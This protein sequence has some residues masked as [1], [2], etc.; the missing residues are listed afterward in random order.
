[1]MKARK[2]FCAILAGCVFVNYQAAADIKVPEGFEALAKGQE[3][4]ISVSLYDENLGLYRA[5]VSLENIVFLQPE[6]LKKEIEKKYGSSADLDTMLSL[7]L[8]NPLKRN[9]GL[10][11]QNNH[12]SLGCGY[13]DP[14]KIAII[15]DES[16][17]LAQIFLSDVFIPKKE[18]QDY[19][20]TNAQESHNGFIHQQNLNIVGDKIS[21]SLSL[22]GNGTLGLAENAYANVEWT[23]N[24]QRYR[25][26]RNSDMTVNNAYVRQDLWKKIYLQVGGMDSRDIFSNSGGSI[27]LSQL[28]LNKIYGVR[29]GS[30]QAW[31]NRD[32]VDRG[33]PLT[34]FLSNDSRVDAYRGN[35]LLGS[36]FLNTGMHKIDTR[37]F[38]SGSYTVSL[39]IYTN[40]QLVRTQ[41]VPYTSLGLSEENNFRWFMQAG[42]LANDGSTEEG[43]K[44]QVIAGGARLPITKSLA[45]TAGTSLLNGVNYTEGALDWT[46][47]F[48]SGPIDGVMTARASY[49]HG[50]DGSSGNVQQLSYNDG[51]SLS[52]Y[53]SSISSPDCGQSRNSQSG[54]GCSTG[55]S[56]SLL[57]SVPIMGWSATLGYTDSR[58]TG[59]YTNIS[60]L[61]TADPRYGH[62][63]PWERVYTTRS[64]SR[65]WQTGLN[66][67]FNWNGL[68]IGTTLNAF[69]RQDSNYQHDD[70]GGYI[71]LNLSRSSSDSSSTF[72]ASWNGSRYSGK[73]LGYGASYSRYNN[74]NNDDEIGASVNGINT[75]S[76]NSS[77]YKR[78]G[79][80]YGRGSLT[81]S[82]S[83]NRN[84]G[85]HTLSVSGSYNSSLAIDRDGFYWGRWGDGLPSSAVTV[86]IK[87]GEK[88]SSSLVNVG[89]DGGK[90]DIS[91]NSRAL[92]TVPGY[93]KTTLSVQESL[94]TSKGISSEIS[95]GAGSRT[96]FMVPG[97]VFNKK[98]SIESRYTWLGRMMDSHHLPLDKAIP[99]NVKSWS[100]LG[101][102][103]FSLETTR[104]LTSL[105]LI[106]NAEYLECP[107][108]VKQTRDVVRWVGT[109]T[110]TPVVFADLPSAEKKQ[111]E[112][113]TAGIRNNE[114]ETASIDK[115][116][117]LP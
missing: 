94:K 30:T 20:F 102:G 115:N 2:S 54:M 84:E 60:Q 23:Y 116:G 24:D 66:K 86:G 22:Q 52:L 55:T 64:R 61:D 11:C 107:V 110:C 90:T 88:N 92:F 71:T 80:Q 87:D 8:Q 13:I 28:Q 81:L 79:G 14:K 53:R 74:N 31:I 39:H 72:N 34:V 69:I 100:P 108:S 6:R 44:S 98:V 43:K 113:M 36:F 33:T 111:V 1:M 75:D 114:N 9:D 15:Y 45:L 91:G 89:V 41:E 97:K 32:K 106:N 70:K 112:L 26:D 103:G 27:N 77:V 59:H 4:W 65:A 40:N 93:Q 21:Q 7:E 101:E 38:P 109:I 51:F 35:Q 78:T 17:D 50:N 25:N 37:N 3:Q 68:N 16:N 62:G 83:Y 95:K 46:H 56:T 10:S 42:V 73:Q 18:S 48:D 96:L 58:S 29:I 105:Y 5:K 49:L 67:T 57:F 47:G 12:N 117:A 76:V 99:L 82:D 63:A 85:A 104:P 19:F